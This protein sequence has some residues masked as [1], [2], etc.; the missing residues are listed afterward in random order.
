MILT[1]EPLP[2]LEDSHLLQEPGIHNNASLNDI[3]N[4]TSLAYFQHSSQMTGISYFS[5][6]LARSDSV[7]G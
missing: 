7:S 6:K 1:E 4:V 2:S 5:S 3:E